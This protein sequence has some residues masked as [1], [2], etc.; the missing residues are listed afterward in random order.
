MA[1]EV[2]NHLK[3]VRL[4]E[5]SE[6][7]ARKVEIELYGRPVPHE[8]GNLFVEVVDGAFAYVTKSEPKINALTDLSKK[9]E[10]ST[11]LLSYGCWEIQHNGQVVIRNGHVLASF[12]G[13]GYSGLFDEI[14]HPCMDLFAPYLRTRTLT[15]CAED[16]LQDAIG[17]VRGL[18]RIMDDER[19]RISPSTPYSDCRNQKQT[20]KVRA[21]LDVLIDSMETQIRN[22]DFC[23]VLLEQSD[24][25]HGLVRIAEESKSL[26][27]NLN[28]AHLLSNQ[29]S[30]ARFTI[31]PFTSAVTKDPYRVLLPTLN[32]LNADR[33]SG[34]YAK[35]A[36][37]SFPPIVWEIKYA[38]LR[39]SEV[40]QIMRL[41][42]EDQTPFDVDLIMRSA[43]DRHFGY[44]LCR[45][46]NNARWKLNPTL[47]KEV[48]EKA[49]ELSR[50]FAAK[51]ADK[52]G[53]TLFPDFRA[54]EAALFPK[55][56]K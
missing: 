50:A 55:T 53:V 13:P 31:L 36:S 4:Q 54:V 9:C 45:A 43:S 26:M 44:E 51:L 33:V 40:K 5:G 34:K 3:V 52:P 1:H 30:A 47:A 42:D 6:D 8:S 22:L 49:I 17:I 18:R 2:R 48:E 12:D 7:F 16:R 29:N 37:G 15:Q 46:S 35:D 10:D 11:F 39:P 19:F 41:P 14:E 25:E 23:G 20:E 56:M 24:L 32:Y 28:L 21:E 27:A 38:C